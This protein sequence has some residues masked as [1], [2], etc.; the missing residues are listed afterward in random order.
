METFK[1]RLD[2]ALSTWWSYRRLYSLQESGTRQPL[3]VPSNSNDS[4]VQPSDLYFFNLET[5][6]WWGTMSKALHKYR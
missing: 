3:S 2:G 5:R 4:M 1:V 6:M